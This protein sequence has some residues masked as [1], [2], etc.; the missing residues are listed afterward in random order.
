MLM[1]LNIWT[2]YSLI[3]DP[4]TFLLR[5]WVLCKVESVCFNWRATMGELLPLIKTWFAKWCCYQWGLRNYENQNVIGR[6]ILTCIVTNTD[7]YFNLC[8]DEEWMKSGAV[9]LPL[10][11]IKIYIT[12]PWL[13]LEY[14]L[15]ACSPT[16]SQNS[17][18]TPY[19]VFNSIFLW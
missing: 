18:R 16:H 13:S 8:E 12:S 3:Y 5:Q 6:Y 11:E 2:W 7:V 4:S 10:H 15:F 14:I 17:R 1:S 19:R 9:I